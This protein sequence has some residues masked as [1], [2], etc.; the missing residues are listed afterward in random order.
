M[1]HEEVLILGKNFN[2]EVGFLYRINEYT[3]NII[4]QNLD[5]VEDLWNWNRKVFNP[6]EEEVAGEDLV[7]VLLVYENSETYM[8][9]VMNSS[10]VFRKYKTN[11]TYFQVG[12]GIYAGLSS[13]LLDQFEQGAYYVEEL[14]LNTESKYGEYL[15]LYMKDF[16][17]G[18]NN[19]TDGLLHDR[20]RWM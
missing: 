10:Q 16:V 4:R 17:M 2:M 18:H 20:V 13:L 1:P 15:N 7:G 6:A 12:C 9:N 14:L 8:Y 3:T 5:Q 19:F 11:A